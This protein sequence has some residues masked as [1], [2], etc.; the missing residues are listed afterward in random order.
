MET[1]P[2]LQADEAISYRA[3]PTLPQ[4]VKDI[5]EYNFIYN[6]IYNTIGTQRLQKLI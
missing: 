6:Y 1:S 2:Q 5:S 3:M 4:I